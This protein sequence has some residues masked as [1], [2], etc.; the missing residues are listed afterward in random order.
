MSFTFEIQEVFPI[1][2]KG[3]TILLGRL[4]DGKIRQGDIIGVPTQDG[5]IV[6]AVITDMEADRKKVN[7][8]EAGQAEVVGFLIRAGIGMTVTLGQATDWSQ[9]EYSTWMEAE[10][11]KYRVPQDQPP[12]EDKSPWW[13]FWRRR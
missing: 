11:Q 9:E 10:R 2:G 13:A 8:V 1:R 12:P 7:E 3:L 4:L 5:A 6:P